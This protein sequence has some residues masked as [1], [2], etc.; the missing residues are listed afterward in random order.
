M[1]AKPKHAPDARLL[2]LHGH[3]LSPVL[4]FDANVAPFLQ[5]SR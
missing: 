5:R 2:A 3:L 4:M 1:Q